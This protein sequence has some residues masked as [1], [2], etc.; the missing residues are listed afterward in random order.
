M[1]EQAQRSHRILLLA[2]L[3]QRQ[4]DYGLT[5]RELMSICE[6]RSISVVFRILKGLESHGLITRTPATANSITVTAAGL[7]AVAADFAVFADFDFI[8]T[9]RL[10]PPA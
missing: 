5:L 7:Q 10:N 9:T 8:P 1:R 3:I 6:I 2:A 4:R